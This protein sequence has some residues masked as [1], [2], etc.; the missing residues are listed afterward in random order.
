MVTQLTLSLETDKAYARLK[1]TLAEKGCKIITE[2]SPKRFLVKQ[3]SLW[4]ISPMNAKKKLDF[5]LSSVDSGT[6]VNCSSKLSSDWTNITFVGC[7]FA[8]V[9][10]GLCV[11]M[12][13]DLTLVI[14]NTKAS[15]WSW[16]ITVNG[17]VDFQVGHA[18]VN[19]TE[20]LAIFLSAIILLEIAITAYVHA[21]IDRFAEETFRSLASS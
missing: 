2:E 19:L 4:G 10:V 13:Y 14:A 16:L 9:L 11:W 20:T 3:G 5:S 1:A 21:R 6:Q 8:A 15:F 18:F 7:A 17:N 12:A